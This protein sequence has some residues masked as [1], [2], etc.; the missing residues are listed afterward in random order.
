MRVQACGV[1]HTDLHYR[2]GGIND[3][4]PFL[5]GHEAA[6]VVESVGD[7]VDERGARRLRGARLARHHAAR[8]APAARDGPGTASTRANAT[9]K[10]TLDGMELSPGA[11]H[12]CVRREDARGGG[13]VRAKVDARARPEAAGLIGCG[14]M[15]GL[16]A[17]MLHGRTCS[18]ATPWP[19]SGAA[20][21]A[22]PPS[23]GARWPARA[24]SSRSTS[25][26]GSWSGRGASAPPTRSTPSRSTRSRPSASS[27]TATAPTCASR[28]WATPRSWSRR[29][30]PATWPAPSC[31]SACRTRR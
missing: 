12:R 6:G 13:A 20:G 19:C 3:E 23:P 4:F 21:W 16:G 25:T 17:A 14:V 26:L 2:E 27:P 28:P 9:Q 5:L 10:M 15:A 30:S 1:C 24:R 31:R 29:S 18:G 8:A 11:R 22:T 7:G